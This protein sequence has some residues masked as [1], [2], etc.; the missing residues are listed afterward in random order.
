MTEIKQS[1]KNKPK[2]ESKKTNQRKMGCEFGAIIENDQH[3]YSKTGEWRDKTPIV[4]EKCIGCG[5]CVEFCPEGAI[6]IKV[7]KRKKRAVID[8]NYCKGC[9]ICSDVCPFKSI[10]MKE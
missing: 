1:L 5:N 10:E 4:T 7:I 3:T 2:K 9:G 6:E 8:Y